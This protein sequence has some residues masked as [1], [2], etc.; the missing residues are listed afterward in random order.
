MTAEGQQSDKYLG[1]T[2]GTRETEEEAEACCDIHI[3]WICF[4][5]VINQRKVLDQI[6]PVLSLTCLRVI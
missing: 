3:P 6:V 5:S 1:T 2:H 4:F